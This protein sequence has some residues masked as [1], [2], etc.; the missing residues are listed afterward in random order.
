MAP[1]SPDQLTAVNTELNRGTLPLI[2]LAILR[3]PQYIL[4]V[5]ALLE[6]HDVGA[7]S[8]T[9]YPLIRRLEKQELLEFTLQLDGNRAKKLYKTTKKG[10]EYIE[11]MSQ[12][13]RKRMELMSE[14][15]NKKE[16]E[17]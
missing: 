16:D 10:V 11:D 12:V 5:I 1:F 9:I 6:A 14:L 8:N 3:K 15:L 17:A 2:V 4:E 7:D 13:W